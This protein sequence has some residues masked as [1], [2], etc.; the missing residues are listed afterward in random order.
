[1]SPFDNLLAIDSSTRALKLA[2]SFGAD[3]LVKSEELMERSHGQVLTKKIGELLASAGLTTRNLHGIVVSIGPGSFT[4]LRIGLAA[5]KGM[6]VALHLP[7]VGI[8]TFEVAAYRLSE[9][10]EPI[11]VLIPLKKDELFMGTVVNG[12]CDLNQIRILTHEQVIQESGELHHVAIGFD[13]Q[14]SLP[15]LRSPDGQSELSFDA[16]YLLQLGRLRLEQ[17]R[18]DDLTT[19][20][21]LYLQ[22]SQAEIRFEQRNRQG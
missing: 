8:S 13:L 5:A 4:G 6:A 16:A 18:P 9:M 22:K 12:A 20:E 7:V 2:V 15:R 11:R 14:H 3:R 17:G 19:L 1:M 10:R 21:P